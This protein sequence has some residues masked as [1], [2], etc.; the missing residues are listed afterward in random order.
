MKNG[1]LK[2]ANNKLTHTDKFN[3]NKGVTLV[4]L[5]V[6]II[7]LLILAGVTINMLLGE[8]GIIKQATKSINETKKAS[9]QE[10]IELTLASWYTD[11]YVNGTS[12]EGRNETTSSGTSIVYSNNV[13]TYKTNDGKS[14]TATVT[15]DGKIIDTVEDTY[16]RVIFTDCSKWLNSSVDLTSTLG[17][18][19]ITI[20]NGTAEFTNNDYKNNLN[21]TANTPPEGMKF[22][23][24]KD[25]NNNI[26]NYNSNFKCWTVREDTILTA[27][28]VDKNVVVTPKVC[29]N[30]TQS[31]LTFDIGQG[32]RFYSLIDVYIPNDYTIISL[33]NNKHTANNLN[34]NSKNYTQL[35]CSDNLIS[36][37]F[38]SF[39]LSKSEYYDASEKY[40]ELVLNFK[41]ANGNENTI[42]DYTILNKGNEP[43]LNLNN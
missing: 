41:D 11:Y 31:P 3:K 42:S 13:L 15:D 7:I 32:Y 1:E 30:I 4:A 8:N 38:Y 28:Y 5:V 24:W 10:E 43:L 2:N 39:Y 26:I 23:Y 33:I 35:L 17:N 34:N 21:I 20:N 9:L 12:L 18:T 27:V 36:D 37:N 22:A 19:T 25:G 6:T 40:Y 16:S 14:Y 29:L